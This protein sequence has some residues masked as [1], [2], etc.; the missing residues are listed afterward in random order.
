MFHALSP[1]KSHNR[2]LLFFEYT[3]L[4]ETFNVFLKSVF[5]KWQIALKDFSRFPSKSTTQI[6]VKPKS[7]KVEFSGPH[8]QDSHPGTGNVW[9]F[10]NVRLTGSCSALDTSPDMYQYSDRFIDSKMKNQK[11]W[12]I[13][14][15]MLV[16][17]LVMQN[18]GGEGW[19]VSTVIN[20]PLIVFTDIR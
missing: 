4:Y 1:E 15:S 5:L 10:N 2:Q 20:A 13:L 3:S 17:F 18:G 12:S 9:N 11:S 14:V 16:T 19:S 8:G 7:S 6:F